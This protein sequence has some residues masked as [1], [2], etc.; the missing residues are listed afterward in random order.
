M[1]LSRISGDTFCLINDDTRRW[2]R[3]TRAYEITSRAPILWSDRRAE[4]AEPA[5][6]TYHA[7]LVNVVT[8]HTYIDIDPMLLLVISITIS[9]RYY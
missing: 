6:N 2:L 3:N 4:W 7:S 5:E 9:T 8:D 1:Q